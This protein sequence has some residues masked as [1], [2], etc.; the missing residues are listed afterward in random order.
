MPG[1]AAAA[2]SPPTPL[3]DVER[4]ELMRLI[5]LGEPIGTFLQQGSSLS[6]DTPEDYRL[7]CRMMERDPVFRARIAPGAPG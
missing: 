5:E 3:E 2:A 6:V 1:L 7:A 4:V